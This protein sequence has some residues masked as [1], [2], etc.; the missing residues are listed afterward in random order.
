MGIGLRSI[1][2]P[3]FGAAADPP[4]IPAS[5]YLARC[6]AAYAAAGTTWLAV[7]ADREHF[8]NIM[9]LSGFEPRFEEALML[10]GAD[11][12]HVIVTGNECLS[13]TVK[14]P[15]PALDAR[16]SQSLSLLGQD[17][18]VHPRLTDVLRDV[19]LAAGD[20]VGLIGWKY[21]EPEEW[22]DDD[23]PFY[24]PDFFVRALRAVVG[25]DQVHDRTEL[26]LH[27]ET[28]L[29][30]YVDAD[31]IAV[32][33][34][35][36]MRGSEMVWGILSQVCVGDTEREAVGRMGYQ[37]DPFNVHMMFASGGTGD[38]PIIGLSSPS[39]RRIAR[40][41]GATT[42][43]GLWG[44]LTARA[45]LV[46]TENDDF[47][48]IAQRYYE[49]LAC[50]YATASLDVTGGTIVA[51]VAET[52]GRGGL[53]SL[54]NPGHLTGHEEW[55]SSPMRPGSA[56]RI[57]SG[58]HMQVD[59]IPTPMPDGW[60]L[61]CEDVIVFADE[62]LRDDLASRH[63]QVA[64]RIDRRRAFMRDVL[65]IAVA[66]CV[67]PLSSTPMCLAPLWLSCDKLIAFD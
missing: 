11:D 38:G 15:L 23:R 32:F 1:A 44:G 57:R 39:G 18:T 61:N 6:R 48:A 37:G 29:R 41:D 14:S 62:T 27:P 66:D 46:A 12:R 4:A 40:G 2:I 13:Y 26:M 25:A 28:G 5:T 36:A 53:R 34:Q 45:G 17:R 22:D 54:L 42:A 31:Q 65:G 63:P 7:Y 35:A 64:A 43:V 19:G 52:L 55:S 47:V 50:W 59:I 58:M 33:E 8:A 16:L 9:Y 60:A 30:S 3:D 67:L 21:L 24:V 49:G 51:A 56:D 20:S 10:I